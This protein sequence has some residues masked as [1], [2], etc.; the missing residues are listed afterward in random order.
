MMLPVAASCLICQRNLFVYLLL[1]IATT[2]LVI[3]RRLVNQVGNLSPRIDNLPVIKVKKL[4]EALPVESTSVG[5]ASPPDT[6]PPEAIHFSPELAFGSLV[7]VVILISAYTK[8]L[9]RDHLEDE[10][11]I[12]DIPMQFAVVDGYTEEERQVV[13]SDADEGNNSPSRISFNSNCCKT[14]RF[15]YHFRA[16]R[17]SN[18]LR[19]VGSNK[20]NK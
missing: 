10:I 11:L 8:N 15:L 5:V 9:K 14:N 18:V 17:Q 1:L 16:P 20:R 13:Q 4:P 2:D 19:R 7:T 6:S 3:A 12:S